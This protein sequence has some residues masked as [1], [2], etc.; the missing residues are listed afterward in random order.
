MSANGFSNGASKQT[1]KGN[2][3]TSNKDE[4]EPHSVAAQIPS[5][6]QAGFFELVICVGGI[7]ASLYVPS[8]PYILMYIID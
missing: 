6:K 4:V 1:V 5:T 2:G 3:Y 7:Y 8:V